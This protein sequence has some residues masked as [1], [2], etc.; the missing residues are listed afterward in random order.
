MLKH[1]KQSPKTQMQSQDGPERSFSQNWKSFDNTAYDTNSISSHME[2]NFSDNHRRLKPN[3]SITTHSSFMQES[4][5]INSKQIHEDC[6]ENPSS[7][8]Q[9]SIRKTIITFAVLLL[10]VIVGV[11]CAAGHYYIGYYL[12]VKTLNFGDQKIIDYSSY[13]CSGVSSDSHDVWLIVVSNLD[14][15]KPERYSM[16]AKIYLEVGQTWSR[17][18]HLRKNSVVN[19]NI[20]SKDII[21]VIVFKGKRNYELWLERKTTISYEM[22]QGCCAHGIVNQADDIE[23]TTNENN[24]YYFVLYRHDSFGSAAHFNATFQFT[25]AKINSARIIRQCK[26]SVNSQ[27]S[28]ALTFASTEKTIIELHKQITKGVITKGTNVRWKCEARIWFYCIVYGLS[29]TCLSIFFILLQKYRQKCCSSYIANSVHKGMGLRRLQST[30]ENMNDHNSSTSNYTS[31][32]NMKKMKKSDVS[33]R[34]LSDES[35]RKYNASTQSHKNSNNSIDSKTSREMYLQANEGEIATIFRNE[36]KI[37]CNNTNDGIVK[38]IPVKHHTKDKIN[39]KRSHE[40]VSI[41]S[42][43]TDSEEIIFQ[44]LKERKQ[45]TQRGENAKSKVSDHCAIHDSEK[46]NSTAGSG[47]A[48]LE[49]D[50]IKLCIEDAKVNTLPVRYHNTNSTRLTDSK[51]ILIGEPLDV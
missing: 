36:S 22:K 37:N 7:Y 31:A 32:A 44:A 50:V 18:F 33:S 9:P 10:V 45:S 41:D 20:S 35:I 1:C 5:S 29:I 27:C 23:F 46:V 15:T 34:N 48:L 2:A 16:Y 42:R 11:S 49:T 39:K 28:V 12:E 43:E 38:Y 3:P 8:G 17:M 47:A 40:F 30:S 25:R 26:T 24:D 4:L 14:Y 19:I 51:I 21:Y 6:N 13:F